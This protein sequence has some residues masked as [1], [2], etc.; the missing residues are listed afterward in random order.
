[1]LRLYGV[2]IDEWIDWGGRGM[3]GNGREEGFGEAL[4]L[5]DVY[6]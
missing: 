1:M 6:F 4:R 5:V 2:L 3:G